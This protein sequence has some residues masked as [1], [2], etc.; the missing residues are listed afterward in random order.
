[1]MIIR[2][3]GKNSR[4]EIDRNILEELI[5]PKLHT[6]LYLVKEALKQA[7]MEVGQVDQ[8]CFD[9]WI[10]KNSSCSVYMLTEFFAKE[11]D[12]SINPDEA[13]AMGAALMAARKST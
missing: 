3:Q 11:F 5:R 2:S 8:N 1:M 7:K 9:R 6:S 13:V 12:C 4:I 10:Y